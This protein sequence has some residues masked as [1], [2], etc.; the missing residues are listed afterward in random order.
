MDNRLKLGLAIFVI[1]ALLFRLICNDSIASNYEV[2]PG[3]SAPKSI[4]EIEAQEKREFEKA[5]AEASVPKEEV[6]SNPQ[7]VDAKQV[8]VLTLKKTAKRKLAK[9]V[10]FKKAKI[11]KQV[12]RKL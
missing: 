4:V 6:K 12:K 3:Y 8:K 10:Q 9:W 7:T 5:L 1:F 2:P 11:S